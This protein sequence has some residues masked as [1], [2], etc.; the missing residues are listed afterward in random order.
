MDPGPSTVTFTTR[1]E[2]C[3]IDTSSNLFNMGHD[4]TPI[5]D[6]EDSDASLLSVGPV[7]QRS[8]FRATNIEL[9]HSHS[10]SN[11]I[12]HMDKLDPYSADDFYDGKMVTTINVTKHKVDRK[13]DLFVIILDYQSLEDFREQIYSENPGTQVVYM[14]R[15]D[16]LE[17][18]IGLYSKDATLNLKQKPRVKFLSEA[19]YLNYFRINGKIR[20]VVLGLIL[21][22]FIGQ[23][24]G[25]V[26]REYFNKALSGILNDKYRERYSIFEGE[27]GH[28][29]PCLDAVLLRSGVFKAV[30]KLM[31]HSLIHCGVA[32]FGIAQPIVE[33]LLSN[34]VDSQFHFTVSAE[35]IPSM[36]VRETIQIVRIFYDFLA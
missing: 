7:D 12:G 21:L 13:N 25:G 27:E 3:A 2:N 30:G 16:F 32:G 22:V 5:S 10:V 19:G 4:Q 17:N 28:K 8:D 31:A 36:E 20:H 35:D 14:A 15:D 24:L 1:H 26:T 23:D 34:D 18:V 33:Y 6:S 11:K 29:V 9:P